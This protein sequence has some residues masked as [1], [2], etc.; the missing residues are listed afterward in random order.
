M[1][2][3]GLYA[4]SA[5][6][7]DELT[8]FDAFPSTYVVLSA[9]KTNDHDRNNVYKENTGNTRFKTYTD[10]RRYLKT[11]VCVCIRRRAAS[12][13]SQNST[14][15]HRLTLLC[16]RRTQTTTIVTTIMRTTDP[17]TQT[18]TIVLVGRFEFPL[19]LLSPCS[20]LSLPSLFSELFRCS[21]SVTSKI[22]AEHNTKIKEL[23]TFIR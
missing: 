16:R 23:K 3:C 19:L 12:T 11:L 15:F 7:L 8:K 10:P 18:G 6:L 1:T 14:R 22:N 5:E 9:P 4:Y 20:S 13:S 21:C 2:V 17:M